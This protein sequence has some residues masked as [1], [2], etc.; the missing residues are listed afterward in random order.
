MLIF[1]FSILANCELPINDF[2]QIHLFV[3]TQKAICV[4]PNKQKLK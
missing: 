4:I 1:K 2:Y 3:K